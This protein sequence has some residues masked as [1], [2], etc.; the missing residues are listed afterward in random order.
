MF[1]WRDSYRVGIREID[2]QHRELFSLIDQLGRGTHD[3]MASSALASLLANIVT[4]AKAHFA[5][6]EQLMR[7]HQYPDIAI[8]KRL[9]DALLVQAADAQEKASRQELTV[10]IVTKFLQFWLG[11]HISE[12][13]HR[14]AQFLSARGV[15]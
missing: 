10:A 4:H 5:T 11:H 12:A 7:Q 14:L 8:H 6:E 15:K 2:A 9:H 3:H 13:D 1:G